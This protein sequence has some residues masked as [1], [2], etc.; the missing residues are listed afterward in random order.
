MK[1]GLSLLTRIHLIIE[2][3]FLR[4]KEYTGRSIF[5]LKKV[6]KVVICVS[7]TSGLTFYRATLNIAAQ[8]GRRNVIEPVQD[9]ASIHGLLLC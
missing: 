2:V 3:I 8:Q 7:K 9:S 6:F 1:N 5:C 4:N